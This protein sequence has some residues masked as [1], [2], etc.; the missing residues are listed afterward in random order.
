M[1]LLLAT[2]NKHKAREIAAILAPLGIDVE[3]PERL[4][5]V[6]EDGETF[7]ANALLKAAS[8][9]KA[10]G[11]AAIADDSGI[12]VPALDGEPGV[13]SARYAGPDATD[14]QN[15]ARLL[16]EVARRGLVDPAAQFVCHAVLAAPDGRVL[17]SAQERVEGV[18][19]GPP[20]GGNGFGYDPVFHHVC[21]RHPPPGCRFSELT[22][23]EKDAESHR[24]KA[25]RALARAILA[26]ERPGS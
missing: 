15:T 11:R 25:F 1:R 17:A 18:V 21:P 5:H 19:R 9:A 10:T 16:A 26:V 4:P 12:V 13:Y 20:R 22:P 24:G 23:A 14:E 8:A 7:A 2:T 6:V 3:T